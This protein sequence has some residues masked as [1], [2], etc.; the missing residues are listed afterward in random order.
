MQT[1]EGVTAFASDEV[2]SQDSDK[3]AVSWDES[4][5][6][7][8]AIYGEAVEAGIRLAAT[9]YEQRGGVPQQI[10]IVSLVETAFDTKA[11]AVACATSLALWK[12]WGYRE[13]DATIAFADGAWNVQFTT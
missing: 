13:S 4:P 10:K 5:S 9:A 7:L 2:V 12:A 6:H 3:W 1:R 11:D 8:Q